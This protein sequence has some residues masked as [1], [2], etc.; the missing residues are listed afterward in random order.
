MEHV[1][2]TP[3][4]IVI[5]PNEYIIAYCDITECYYMCIDMVDH[6]LCSRVAQCIVIIITRR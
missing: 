3:T 2:N 4:V 6:M 5:K 1:A